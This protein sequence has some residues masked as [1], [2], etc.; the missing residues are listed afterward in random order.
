MI[1]VFIPIS[2]GKVKTDVRG[3]WYS[4]DSHKIYYDYLKIVN[5]SYIE[6]RQL[7]QLK[8]KYNQESIF[9]FDTSTDTGKIYYSRDKIE[10]L[11]SRIIKE[12]LRANLRAE[13]KEALKQYGGV[14]IY[15]IGNK[16]YKEIFYNEVLK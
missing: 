16:Y 11:H 1:K 5:T 6:T 3:F 15:E 9:Y 10:V 12:V 7:E 14:T 13:I 8:K 2:K 4:K